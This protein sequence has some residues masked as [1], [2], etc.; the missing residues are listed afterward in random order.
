V[1]RTLCHQLEGWKRSSCTSEP[2]ERIDAI[3]ENAS[4][5]MWL[6]GSGVMKRSAWPCSAARSPRPRY[7][8]PAR[9]K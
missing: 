6:S 1:S 2:P 5:F 8:S 3:V 7:H 9:M 4:A